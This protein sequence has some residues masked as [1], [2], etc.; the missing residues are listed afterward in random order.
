MERDKW[1]GTNMLTV[2]ARRP[3]KPRDGGRDLGP[4]GPG[5]LMVIVSVVSSEPAAAAACR[6]E[7]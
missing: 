6:I 5:P 3:A 7:E 2:G 1:G 4:T